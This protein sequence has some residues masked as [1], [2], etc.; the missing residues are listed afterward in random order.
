MKLVADK[1]EVQSYLIL[2]DDAVLDAECIPLLNYIHEK[3]LLPDGC[4]VLYLGGVLPPNK[5]GFASVVEPVNECIGRIKENTLFSE[6]PSRNFHFCAYS[7]ILRRSGA[8][9]LCAMLKRGCWAP[10]DHLLCNSY[11]ELNLYCTIPIVAGCYQDTDPR[12]AVSDFNTFGKEDYDSDLRNEDVFSQEEIL[13]STLPGEFS[14]ERALNVKYTLP[15]KKS[16]LIFHDITGLFEKQWLEDILGKKLD[17]IETDIPIVLYQKPHCEKLMQTLRSWPAFTLLHLSDEA[18][19]DPIELYDWP[20]CKGVVRNYVRKGVSS[21]VTT[22]PLGYHWSASAS[23]SASASQRRDLLWSF[24]GAEHGE[25]R[26]KLQ[27]FKGILPNKCIFQKGWNSP[28]KCGKEEVIDSLQRSMCVPC[29][30]G[31]NYETFRIYEAL[32]AGAVPILVEEPGSVEFLA[33]LKKWIPLATSPDWPTAARVAY[34]LTQNTELYRDYRKS[35]L[36]GW[37]SL[38]AWATAQARKTLLV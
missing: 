32:E 11:K 19:I 34:G 14:L 3:N 10:A 29:P 13:A 25:R 27:A 5:E 37:A 26:D 20:A 4:D 9:K 17:E 12:Y 36:V 1:P 21:K 7:Y 30:G 18:C 6:K 2:E 28:E 8:E 23:G 31:M 24:I 33:Y 38:K 16:P 22:I 35:L 15:T